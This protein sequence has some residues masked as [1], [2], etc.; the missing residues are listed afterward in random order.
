[1]GEVHVIG[2]ATDQP[3]RLDADARAA[4]AAAQ[5][6]VGGR[7]HLTVFGD[8]AVQADLRIEIGADADE[9]AREVRRHAVDEGRRVCV[10]A[11][12]DPGFFGIVR[13]LSRTLDRSALRIHPAPSAV[14]LAFARLGLP[15][16]D[17]AVVSA[18]GRPLVDAIAAIRGWPKVA[19]LTSPTSPP[20]AIGK[21]LAA[22]GAT[23]DLIAVCS[24]L[25]LAGEVVTETDLAG[26]A[27]GTFEPLSVVVLAGP[28]GLPPTGWGTG[29]RPALAWGLPDNAFAHHMITRA[30][31][32]WVVLGK[33]AL[34]PTGVM[35]DVGAGSGSV[36]IECALARPSLA[37]LAIERAPEAAARIA[38]NVANLGAGVHLV[39]GEAPAVLDGLPAPDRV[40]VGGGGLDVLRASRDRL[41]P[42]GRVV[43]TF[44]ALDRAA[45]A[46]CLLG[47]LVQV[48]VAQGERLPD[49]GLRLVA[50]N[51]VFV[52]WGPDE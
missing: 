8:L 23:F 2:V 10:L 46:A 29:D 44:A 15:W 22:A 12:G 45:E 30:E 43:A 36:A 17:A 38:A 31:V 14:S 48:G 16:D 9:V 49:G 11:S 39:A 6:L 32:R 25:G 51:P 27:A 20:E 18:H 42:G 34:P 7:R 21:A 47:N 13:A 52:A 41:A 26:L 5:V 28:G 24:H 37:V 33:L 50:R 40:F 3:A 19:V 35:W 1:V 4:L